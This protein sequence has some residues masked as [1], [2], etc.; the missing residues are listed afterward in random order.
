MAAAAGRERAVGGGGAG[1]PPLPRGQRADDTLDEATRKELCTDTFCKVC[2]AVLQFE[3]QRVSHYE[4][5][6][7]AQKVRLYLQMHSEQ[8]E[9]QEPGKQKKQYIN[10]Q[11]DPNV[12]KNTYCS[13]CNMI[14]TSPIVAQS[15]YLGKIHAKK[16]KQ[17]SAD[18]AQQ[19]PTQSTQ[20]EPGHSAVPEL[21]HESTSQDVDSEDPSLSFSAPFDLDN[22]EKYCKLCLAPFNNP[23]MAHQHYVGKKHKRN[24]ERKKLMAEIGP[25]AITGES[26]AN[27]GAGNYTCPICSI[28]L[29][30]IEMYQSHMKGNKHHTKEAMIVSLMKNTKSTYNSFQD[31]LADYI[32]VQKA[33]GLEPK[34]NFRTLEEEFQREEFEALSGQEKTE[35]NQDQFL[36][37][38]YEPDQHSIFS[39]KTY[40]ENTLPCRSPA[41]ANPRKLEKAPL[42]QLSTEHC[43]EKQVS[44]LT[45]CKRDD[46]DRLSDEG[47]VFS[48]RSPNYYRGSQE[49]NKN[50][51]K[52][53]RDGE[54]NLCQ[55]LA[56][57][58]RK[59][60]HKEDDNL[61]KDSEKQKQR[62]DTADSA[63][64]GKSKHSKDKGNNESFSEKESRKHK[65]EKKK[66]KVSG[67]TEEEILWNESILGF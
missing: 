34:T 24:E 15:H 19:H 5:K 40:V 47:L 18:P 58:K 26:K 12:D 29:T 10:F 1:G 35:F 57:C 7:H 38:T 42:S 37:D 13:L 39:T 31:E 61:R 66:A 53:A 65:K 56:K 20:P 6:K 9:G 14:F 23:L 8:E 60:Y 16:L 59:R 62:Q 25:E 52:Y 49:I 55:Q 46:T 41:L 28:S 44:P 33:R 50:K 32:K 48:D 51:K 17:L 11:M 63:T 67:P 30:S 45:T 27:I 3:S 21:C 43:S 64:E 22:P 54:K 4:G 2:G 36:H